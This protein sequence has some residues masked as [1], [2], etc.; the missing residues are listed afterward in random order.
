MKRTDGPIV[1]T[2]FLEFY[3]RAHHL[4]Y[5]KPVFNFIYR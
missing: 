3:V 1:Y 4:E 2:G 5:I